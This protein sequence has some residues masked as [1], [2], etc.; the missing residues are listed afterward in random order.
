MRILGPGSTCN[1]TA[2]GGGGGPWLEAPSLSPSS[3]SGRSLQAHF[4][5]GHRLPLPPPQTARMRVYPK[6]A[7]C[8][9]QPAGPVCGEHDGWPAHAGSRVL[10]LGGGL[11]ADGWLV[12]PAPGAHLAGSCTTGCPAGLGWLTASG[13]NEDP[14]RGRAGGFLGLEGGCGNF[15]SVDERPRSPSGLSSASVQNVHQWLPA[16]V[17]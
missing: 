3:V 1:L 17:G 2:D 10:C 12:L 6:K 8:L 13:W 7:A 9:N 5:S 15:L 16:L 14:R 11:H 4:S